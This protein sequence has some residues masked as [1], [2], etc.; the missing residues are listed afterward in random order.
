MN[1]L[2]VQQTLLSL[3]KPDACRDVTLDEAIYQEMKI[4]GAD[5]CDLL[6]EI[7]EQFSLP[8]FSWEQFADTSEPPRGLSLFGRFKILPRDR[9]TSR[10]LSK[11]LIK[12]R[13][14][15]P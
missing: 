15:E 13:W 9:L 1:E 11:V 5:F 4:N 8:E 6:C 2:S 14:F 10:H 7:G 12:G 3:A